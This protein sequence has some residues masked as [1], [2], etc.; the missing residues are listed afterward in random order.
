LPIEGTGDRLTPAPQ[1]DSRLQRL[2]G[3][4]PAPE[5]ARAGA[6]GPYGVSAQTQDPLVA[7]ETLRIGQPGDGPGWFAAVDV[8]LV[9]PHVNNRVSSG[10]PVSP[11]A[12]GPV[13]LPVAQLN[14]TVSPRFELG[15]RMPDGRGDLRLG[16]RFLASSGFEAGS[17]AEY[18]RSRLDLNVVDLDYV[19][20]E[21]LA[22][23]WFGPFRDLRASFGV[24]LATSYLDSQARGGAAAEE[25]FTSH[26]VGAGP[27]FG[28][29]WARPLPGCPLELC[30][31]FDAAG[32]VGSVRQGFTQAGTV[33]R[34]A[35]LTTG[36]EV[37]GAEVGL[38]WRPDPTGRGRVVVGY[39][40]QQWW[41]LG[42]TDTSNFD[43]T[44]Q[45]AFLRAEWRY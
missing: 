1:A 26:F 23:N 38:G 31:R 2:F 35:G 34:D 42:R 29:E 11:L 7:P 5:A 33:R 30:T 4:P 14:W 17:G 21:W 44:V 3:G 37:V 27:R 22:E 13:E 24:R 8:G 25:R 10:S 19:S 15:Y 40:F 32:L 41:D 20:G 18:L 16:Y 45:G 6:V 39:Q 43:L 9:H 28:L 36:V 12:A